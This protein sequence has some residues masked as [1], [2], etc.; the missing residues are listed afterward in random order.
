MGTDPAL[1]ALPPTVP[2][3]TVRTISFSQRVLP[4][5]QRHGCAACHGGGGGLTVSTVSQL[6]AGGNHGPAVV[7]GQADNSVLIKKLLSPPPFGARMPQGGPYL[8]DSTIG[9]LRTW[10]DEGALNN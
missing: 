1:Q 3:G 2:P 9:V 8:P 7:A 10:I 4:I 6:L 5:F